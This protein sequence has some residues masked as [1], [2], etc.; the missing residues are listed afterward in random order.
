LFKI[1]GSNN[2]AV[3]INAGKNT[4]S[5]NNNI[6]IGHTGRNGSESRVMRIGKAQTKTFVAG[7]SGTPMSGTTVV[8]SPNGQLG[9]VASSARYK[10]VST[11]PGHRIRF[12]SAR[13]SLLT[14]TGA[15]KK[16]CRFNALK[17]LIR[18]TSPG[19]ASIQLCATSP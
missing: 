9:V 12:A 7:I 3:G 10:Q 17:L 5:G 8:V 11:Y 4:T 16:V 13:K 15:V 19:V 2:I 6:Y 1:N 18:A 14:S